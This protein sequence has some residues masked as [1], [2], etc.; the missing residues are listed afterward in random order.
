MAQRERAFTT[1]ECCKYKGGSSSRNV[2]FYFHTS[3]QEAYALIEK[4]EAEQN[5]LYSHQKFLESSKTKKSRIPPPPIL[6]AR[7]HRSVTLKPAP[8]FS[9]TKVRRPSSHYVGLSTLITVMAPVITIFSTRIVLFIST[10]HQVDVFMSYLHFN[11]FMILPLYELPSK[12]LSNTATC[13]SP[14]GAAAR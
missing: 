5:A 2:F 12:A 7:T 10:G 9:D 11:L 13:L 1:R 8:F 4:I 6:L 3:L 14:N